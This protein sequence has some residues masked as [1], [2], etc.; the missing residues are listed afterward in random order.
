VELEAL[1]I[2]NADVE[3]GSYGNV[4]KIIEYAGVNASDGATLGVI[5]HDV[6]TTSSSDGTALDVI[7]HDATTTSPSNE[8]TLNGLVDGLSNEL[9][10]VIHA[11][12]SSALDAITTVP[13]IAAPAVVSQSAPDSE[14]DASSSVSS[15]TPV[16]AVSQPALDLELDAS[17]SATANGP[18]VAKH[19]A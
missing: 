13:L 10:D 1:S 17:S 19:A 2:D 12:S 4:A 6:A 9:A 16:V 11:G 8:T 18:T 15:A 3:Y 7:T 5:A 14:L